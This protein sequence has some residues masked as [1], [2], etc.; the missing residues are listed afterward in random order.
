MV[1][2][3]FQEVKLEILG[4]NVEVIPIEKKTI[5]IDI[6]RML[7]GKGCEAKF[8]IKKENGGF[9]GEIIS[10][11]LFPSYIRR[12]IHTGTSIIEDS[13]LTECKDAK[14]KIKPLI[15][16]RNKVHRSVRTRLRNEA[17]AEIIELCKNQTRAEI[18]E[19]ILNSVMQ[20]NLSKKLKII[21]PLAFCDIRK[22]EVKK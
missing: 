21:Y 20:K 3:K 7:R 8:V 19:S 10:L 5:K 11:S 18:F 9:Y 13:F 17:K 12:I 22:I 16:T 14:L 15:I 2:A 6:T 1:K 4:I